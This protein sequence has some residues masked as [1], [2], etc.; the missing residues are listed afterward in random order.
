MGDRLESLRVHGLDITGEIL[1]LFVPGFDSIDQQKDKSLHDLA[2]I[3]AETMSIHA[4][5]TELMENEPWDYAAVYY[6]GIDHFSHRF[7]R[8]H[9]G[10][11]RGSNK[12]DPALYQDVVVNAYRY[13][14]AMLGRLLHLAGP[15]CAIMVLSDHGFH[16]D[17]LLPDYIPAEAAGPAVEHRHFG[18]FCLRATRRAPR[19]ARLRSECARYRAH[20]AAPVR[21][22]RRARYGWQGSDQR[23]PGPHPALRNP[24]LGGRSRRRRQPPPGER[25]DSDA[26]AESLKQLVALGYIAPPGDNVR[27]TVDEC[28]AENRYNQARAWLDAGS[29]AQAAEILRELIARDAEQSRFYRHLFECVVRQGDWKGAA[30]VL[31]DYDRAAADL[32]PA[33]ARN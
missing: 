30:E 21:T 2:G 14:D 7:M 3:V 32:R 10:K 26:S 24:E 1:R 6:S 4:A 29:P 31:D 22:A 5:A 17:S 33:R 11:A 9:A 16:S 18:I 12:T 28:V 27:K 15:D 8:H 20:R 19:T 23:L 13:H 25:Y